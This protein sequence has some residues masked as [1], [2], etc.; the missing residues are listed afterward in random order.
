ME[1]AIEFRCPHCWQRN[2]LALD[3][4]VPGASVIQDCEVCCN[5]IEISYRVVDGAIA[6][7]EVQPA[8]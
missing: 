3:P 8:Q 6:D 5:P 1:D 4:G 7:V 2:V